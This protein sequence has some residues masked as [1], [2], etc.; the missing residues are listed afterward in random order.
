M[1][2]TVHPIIPKEPTQTLPTYRRLL[3][4]SSVREL[5]GI[6]DSH[7]YQLIAEGKFPAPIKLVKGGRASA[8]VESE[9]LEWIDQRIADS[10]SA[11]QAGG[12]SHD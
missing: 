9:I 2:D 11:N 12:A 8:W 1:A 4:K 7:M 3:R 5:T 6:S 10:R